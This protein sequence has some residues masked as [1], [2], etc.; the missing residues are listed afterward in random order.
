MEDDGVG[1]T[2]ELCES[3]NKIMQEKVRS[4][5]TPKN[6]GFGIALVN[7]NDR[8][9]LLDGIEYGIRMV[10]RPEGGTCVIV[11]Q[12]YRTEIPEEDI[13]KLST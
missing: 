13:E 10:K 1:V 11:T 9:R 3:L 8:I 2:E 6:K 4:I 12:K 7:V 5:R